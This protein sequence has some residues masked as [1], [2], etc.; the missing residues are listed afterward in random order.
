MN[1]KIKQVHGNRLSNMMELNNF[2][3]NLTVTGRT[4]AEV[5]QTLYFS[6]PDVSPNSAEDLT[7]SNEDQYYSGNYLVTAIRHKINLLRHTMTMEIVKDS[8]TNKVSR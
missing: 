3:L 6:Y 5:G 2:K 7:K 8:L 4:D 1:E